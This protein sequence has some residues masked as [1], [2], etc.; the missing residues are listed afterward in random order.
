MHGF[1]GLL[2]LTAA[3]AKVSLAA[4]LFV[5]AYIGTINSLTLTEE[6]DGNY[7]LT[8]N[9]SLQIGG[10]P[11][12]LTWNAADRTLYIPD[13]SEY[14]TTPYSWS[15]YAAPNGSFSLTGRAPAPGGGVANGLYGNNSYLA[16]AHYDLSELSTFK[17][18]L[19]A[20]STPLQTFALTMTGPG[21]IP[22]RQNAAHP[23]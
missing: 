1:S 5:S 18:P 22:S 10:Q 19:T 2:V 6:S 3:F 20:S 7:S 8:L 15:V 4:N 21:T 12:W 23:H 11:S 13:E 14:F 17:F 9:D 16:T